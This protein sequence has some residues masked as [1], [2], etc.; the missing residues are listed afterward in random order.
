MSRFSDETCKQCFQVCK[1]VIDRPQS[2]DLLAFSLGRIEIN[3]RHSLIPEGGESLLQGL[4]I[5]IVAPAGLGAFNDAGD[6]SVFISVH[7]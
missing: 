3:D 7:E 6:H 5:V 4:D 2:V 1:D